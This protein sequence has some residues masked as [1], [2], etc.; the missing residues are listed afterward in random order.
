MVGVTL[1]VGN[2]SFGINE[3]DL[4]RFFSGYGKLRVIFKKNSYGFVRFE[5]QRDA[6]DAIYDLNNRN[7]NGKKIVIKK[8]ANRLPE[9]DFEFPYRTKYRLIIKNL[10]SSVSWQNLKDFMKHH[11]R[12]VTYVKI[13]RR[14]EGIVEFA[15]YTQMKSA[16]R[17]MRDREFEGRRIY[18]I[19]DCDDSEDDDDSE[20]GRERSPINLKRE[21]KM[22]LD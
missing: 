3:K 14:H 17:C 13:V 5:N 22:E 15:T 7:F 9:N 8:T 21:K 16:M 10:S 2:L 18:M 19:Q 11:L 20:S 12:G 1:Y 6:D 4:K